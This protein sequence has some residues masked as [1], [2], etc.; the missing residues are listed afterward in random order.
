[1]TDNTSTDER[2]EVWRQDWEQHRETAR[3][4]AA[5]M[6]LVAHHAAGDDLLSLMRQGAETAN[7][8]QDRT[9]WTRIADRLQHEISVATGAYRAEADL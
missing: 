2:V 3:D 9:A 7:G 8:N 1:M 6:S 4:Y 5:V